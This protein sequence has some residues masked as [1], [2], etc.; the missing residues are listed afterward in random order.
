MIVRNN[1]EALV[2]MMN[3][4]R[5]LI[6]RF[7]DAVLVLIQSQALLERYTERRERWSRSRIVRGGGGSW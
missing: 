3:G 1:E 7:D 4:C 2:R 6:V 5:A